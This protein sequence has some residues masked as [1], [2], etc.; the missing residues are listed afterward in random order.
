MT[1]VQTCALPICDLN[2]SDNPVEF[3]SGIE[4]ALP[5]NTIAVF[6]PKGDIYPL[7]EGSTL[8]DFAYAIHGDIGDRCIG[9]TVN[10]KK[11]T[12]NHK[13]KSKNEV[14]I[15]TS[16]NQTPRKD[17]LTF[18]VTAKAKQYIKRFLSKKEKEI[19]ENR[20]REILKPLFISQGRGGD[21]DSLKDQPAFAKIVDR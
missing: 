16:K 19:T 13:L 1:G 3:M 21:F 5:L 7:P 14:R 9:G 6:S 15:E 4:N 18:V 2:D 8:L 17:W 10:G 12:I 11:V 20:G